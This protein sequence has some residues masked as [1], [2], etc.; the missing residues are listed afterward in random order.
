MKRAWYLFCAA[1][2]I[3]TLIACQNDPQSGAA[4]ST[5]ARQGPI[6][7]N[8]FVRYIEN[9]KHIKAEAYFFEGNDETDT[10]P[11]RF[12]KGVKFLGSGMG[13]RQM[14][15]RYYKYQYENTIGWQDNYFFTLTD[16]A[17]NEHRFEFGESQPPLSDF[18]LPATLHRGQVNKVSFSPA[19][20]PEG[21][22]VAILLTDANNKAATTKI[23]GP[24][25]EGSI[26]IQPKLL[27]KLQSGPAEAYLVHVQ[28]KRIEKPPF[29]LSF[30]V[31]YYTPLQKTVIK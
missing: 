9:D 13:E 11:K 2:M 10:K 7:G 26:S 27:E 6:K 3:F 8:L 24:S 25:D 30:T 20:L 21:S 17:G 15:D 18:Q 1:G 14:G 4:D 23:V 19:H 16:D 31:E 29:S 5:E 22:Y 28:S 12:A